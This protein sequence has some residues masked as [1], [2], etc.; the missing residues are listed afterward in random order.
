MKKFIFIL[1]GVCGFAAFQGQKS[2]NANGTFLNMKQCVGLLASDVL[3]GRMT[4]SGGEL[5]A[6]N[7]IA[8]Q[9]KLAG[10]TPK[11]DSSW[12]QFFEGH[13]S[14]PHGSGDGATLKG[15]NV[16]G[17]LDQHATKTIV[18]GAH[19]DHLGMGDEN[20]LWTGEKSVHN[21]ADDNA[22]G[23]AMM[24]HL[25]DYVSKHRQ[26]LT[27]NNYLFIAFSGEEKGLWGSNY[28]VKHPTIPLGQMNYM[29]NMDMVGR[30][31]QEQS[32]AINGSGTSPQWS[33][34][35]DQIKWDGIKPIYSESGVGPSDQTSFYLADIPAIHFFTGQHEDYH[36]PTDDAEKINYRG[37][38]KVADIIEQVLVITNQSEKLAFTKTKEQTPSNQD[39]KVT[40]GVMPD[41]M[42]NG[43]GLR[44]DGT[45]E[46]RPGSKAGLQ[47]GDI[48]LSIGEFAVGD[49]YEYMEALGKFEKGQSTKMKVKR[50]EKEIELPVTWE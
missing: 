44:I 7:F 33:H 46:G 25:A 17:Y 11:G 20:S 5:M 27:Q 18:I 12:F 47:K 3:E 41:Y 38:D 10:L 13:V 16:I 1:I 28:Y 50:G 43:P 19:Y 31:N 32:L 2:L 34:I 35:F 48:I 49:I 21:G 29:I 40:L 9:M 36:K 23:V 45:K 26:Q 6:A 39:F 15:M 37:M 22:S 4:G 30:L 8:D 24:L 14:G 42:Y